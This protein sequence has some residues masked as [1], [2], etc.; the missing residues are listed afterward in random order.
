MQ[1]LGL[2]LLGLGLQLLGLQLLG[3]RHCVKLYTRSSTNAE[4]ILSLPNNLGR[5]LGLRLLEF[6]LLGLQL[7]GLDYVL[8]L[9]CIYRDY[10]MGYDELQL[11]GSTLQLLELEGVLG[12]QLL[13]L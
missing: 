10:Q 9:L 4:H 1:L 11:L 8:G 5:A 2:R 6:Q 12:L 3:L 13:G 7:L